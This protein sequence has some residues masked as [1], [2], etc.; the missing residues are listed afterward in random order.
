M[1][2]RSS[3]FLYAKYD[4]EPYFT[5]W[6]VTVFTDTHPSIEQITELRRVL[7]RYAEATAELEGWRLSTKVSQE[8]EQVEPGESFGLGVNVIELARSDG[9]EAVPREDREELIEDNDRFGPPRRDYSLDEY[10]E[11]GIGW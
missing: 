4:Y 5:Y 1:I 7:V 9:Q 8:I 6:R 11:D 3:F 2:Y 10:L